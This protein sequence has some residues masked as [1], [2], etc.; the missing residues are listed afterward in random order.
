MK[1]DRTDELVFDD[2]SLDRV[3]YGADSP[4]STPVEVS[5]PIKELMDDLRASAADPEVSIAKIAAIFDSGVDLHDPVYRELLAMMR[6]FVPDRPRP[7]LHTDISPLGRPLEASWRFARGRSDSGLFVS[8]GTLMYR[9]HEHNNRFEEARAV[10]E[11]LIKHH[12]A[13]GDRG[14]EATCR[15]NLG[16]EFLYERKWEEALPAFESAA[17]LFGSPDVG[18]VSNYLNAIANSQTCRFEL[19][20]YGDIDSFEKE[21]LQTARDMRGNGS[22]HERKPLILAA[23]IAE[24]RGRYEQA[25]ARA[26]AAIE[27]SRNSGTSW[28]NSDREYLE[29]LESRLRPPS[30]DQVPSADS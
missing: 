11:E 19:R 5:L 15:N 9:W 26:K 2:E 21:V 1:P 18:D 24:L 6:K 22:W 10:L 14:R 4:G 30:G 3:L 25:I 13:R 8:A 29:Q 27:S 16:F 23:R 17:A 28:E 20:D 7:V 12:M